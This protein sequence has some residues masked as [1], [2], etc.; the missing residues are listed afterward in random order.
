MTQ[1]EIDLKTII[2]HFS[3]WEVTLNNHNSLNLQDSNVIAEHTIC[4]VLNCIFDYQLVNIN[5]PNA[6]HIAIDLADK[7]NK[8]AFQITTTKSVKKIHDTLVKFVEHEL[9]QTYE[10]LYFLILGKRQR[11]YPSL[12]IPIELN[13]NPQTNIIDFQ[14]LLKQIHYLTNAKLI[15]LKNIIVS[16]LPEQNK[17]LKSNVANGQKRALMMKKR[18]Y[19]DFV[20]NEF[21]TENFK[22][23]ISL[24][25][26]PFNYGS[27][28]VRQVGDKTFPG[29]DFE[30][31]KWTKI[32][33]FN[34]YDYG[35]EFIG[36]GG[37]LIMDNEGY[38]DLLH[39]NDSRRNNT[40][41]RKIATHSF[42]R[43]FYEDI[44]TYELE[45]DPYYGYPTIF[46]EFKYDNWPFEDVRF[47]HIGKAGDLHAAYYYNNKKRKKLS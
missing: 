24:T 26:T 1:R 35:V 39:N 37:D 32:E 19:K 29:G 45:T 28:I 23:G 46:C 15:K 5:T 34:L 2:H 25:R 14:S 6:N 44:L 27:A 4:N 36:H 12:K 3:I 43:L 21:I 22:K 17:N 11:N 42:C 47:G 38:W 10:N 18:F 7:K 16:N 9:H 41:Y 40:N 33:F 20:D 8:I 31:P 30:F 13:F